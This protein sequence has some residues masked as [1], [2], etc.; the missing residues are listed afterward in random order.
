MPRPGQATR[1]GTRRRLAAARRMLVWG[2][3]AGL[4]ASLV[5]VVWLSDG[6]QPSWVPA[7]IIAPVVIYVLWWL[8]SPGLRGDKLPAPSDAPRDTTVLEQAFD[9][10]DDYLHTR[11]A[12]GEVTGSF[13]GRLRESPYGV[14]AEL[15]P[16]F[17]AATASDPA[18]ASDEPDDL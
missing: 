8:V 16:R 2:A 18:A 13:V 10:P 14:P 1:E 5:A 3:L 4:A 12:R 6:R 11:P 17:R 9:G 7:M 15:R